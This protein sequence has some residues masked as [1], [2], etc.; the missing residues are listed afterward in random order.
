M[1]PL[2]QLPIFAQGWLQSSTSPGPFHAPI[3]S[4][5]PTNKQPT[6]PPTKISK[7]PVYSQRIW[8]QT[9][10][11]H[12]CS[13]FLTCDPTFFCDQLA[14]IQSQHL[15]LMACWCHQMFFLPSRCGRRSLR[16]ASAQT[17]ENESE[18]CRQGRTGTCFLLAGLLGRGARKTKQEKDQLHTKGVKVMFFAASCV[19]KWYYDMICCFILFWFVFLNIFMCFLFV[20]GL[21]VAKPTTFPAGDFHVKWSCSRPSRDILIDPE[22]S[23]V[24]CRPYQNHHANGIEL[25]GNVFLIGTFK[26]SSTTTSTMW[27]F[28]PIS[29]KPRSGHLHGTCKHF[30]WTQARV[31][32]ACFHVTCHP[33]SKHV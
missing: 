19:I 5:S 25:S 20:S 23:G 4:C 33:I 10:V 2:A 26:K 15:F 11:R 1:V 32:M 8:R 3:R 24:W 21:F 7:D 27:T 13:F 31:F 18:R 12:S 16:L 28:K 14:F 22:C 9:S 17:D 6:A 29:T 30:F